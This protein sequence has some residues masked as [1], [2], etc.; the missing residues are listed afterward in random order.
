ML[1]D[2]SPSETRAIVTMLGLSDGALSSYTYILA[3]RRRRRPLHYVCTYLTLTT[4]T[5]HISLGAYTSLTERIG[6]WVFWR[7]YST[8]SMETSFLSCRSP[9]LIFAPNINL[10]SN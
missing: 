10:Q 1:H 5:T 3:R 2:P 8:M 4:Y 7:E 9:V 6:N